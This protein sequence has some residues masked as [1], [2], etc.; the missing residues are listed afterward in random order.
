[1]YYELVGEGLMMAKRLTR[2]EWLELNGFSADGFTY[3]AFGD[4]TYS[5]KGWLKEQGCKFNPILKWHNSELIDMPVGYGMIC[6][7][8]DE[9]LEWDEEAGTAVYK[10]KAPELVDR[11]FKEAEGPSFS[12]YVGQVG[13]RLRNITAIYKSTR[14]F[15]GMYGWTN[16]HTFQNGDDVLVWFTAKD[17]DLEKGAVVDLTGTVKKH[18]EFR[19]V[20]TTQLSRCII[21]EVV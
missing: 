16:I 12:E 15:A 1:M 13:E 7:G 8:F 21:K 18:E 9:I 4:D 19:G 6:F 2:E 3:S 5:I 11:R 14:G 17:L 10:E 20:K